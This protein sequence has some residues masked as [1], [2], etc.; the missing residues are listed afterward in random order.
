MG[1]L[2]EDVGWDYG[3][4]IM[5]VG[6]RC[7]WVR[8]KVLLWPEPDDISGSVSQYIPQLTTFSRSPRWAAKLFGYEVRLRLSGRA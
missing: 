1:R 6:Y 3:L 2:L 8:T 4:G 5:Y 7:C